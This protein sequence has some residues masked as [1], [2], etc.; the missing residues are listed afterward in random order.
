[1]A[2]PNRFGHFSGASLAGP[3]VA[4]AAPQDGEHEHALLSEQATL[5][6]SRNAPWADG[7][8]RE[9]SAQGGAEMRET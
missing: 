4:R 1:M 8:L 2:K 3:L 7:S 6:L 5:V 9:P